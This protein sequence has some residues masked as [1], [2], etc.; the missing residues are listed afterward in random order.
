MESLHILNKAKVVG[1]TSTGAAKNY[2]LLR[3]LD[4]E[5]LMIEEAGQVLESHILACLTPNLKH[6]ILIGDHQQLKP[7]VATYE[8]ALKYHLDLSMFE[9]LIRNGFP[10]TQLKEQHR[11]RP[12]I[13]DLIRC[14]FYPDLRDHQSVCHYPQVKGVAQDVFF[15]NHTELEETMTDIGSMSKTNKSEAQ[16]LIQ[17]ALYLVEQGYQAGK[18]TILVTYLGQLMY[19]ETLV[20]KAGFEALIDVIIAVVDNY[21]GEENDIILLSLVRSNEAGNI[22]YLRLQNRIC[23]ALSRARHGLYVVGNFKELSASSKSWLK[24]LAHLEAKQQ[25]SHEMELYCIFHETSR[26]WISLKSTTIGSFCQNQCGFQLP[27]GLHMCETRCHFDDRAHLTKHKCLKNMETVLACGHPKKYVCGDILSCDYLCEF[28]LPCGHL[29]H[30]P[31]HST[32][33]EHN[34]KCWN[35]CDRKVESCFFESHKCSKKCGEKCSIYCDIVIP[36]HELKCGHTI[37]NVACADLIDH[38]CMVKCKKLLACGIHHC[39]NYCYECVNGCQPCRVLTNVTLECGHC[40]KIA[41]DKRLDKEGKCIEK[42]RKTLTC[43]HACPLLCYQP[44]ETAQ[45][46]LCQK[47]L[48]E[49]TIDKKLQSSLVVDEEQQTG[50]SNDVLDNFF[51]K[52][53]KKK[54]IAKKK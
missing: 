53:D 54:K 49:G 46:Q 45:C 10:F 28:C 32:E 14:Q 34:S 42:C 33:V 24:I 8:L 11:M 35:P 12:E 40:I 1:M 15:L 43:G 22:G 3:L 4:P 2:R 7:A 6:L 26:A 47:D 39:K 16:F 27:C 13:A 25:V 19:L 38:A 30:L 20:K 9:R 51:A 21:Q 50:S 5:V 31:C 48:S 17:L 23:V 44:C 37:Q 29:C 41:C 36:E 18:I 52:K